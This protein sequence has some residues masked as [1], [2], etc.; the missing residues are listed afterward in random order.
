MKI[1]QL[2]SIAA[3]ALAFTACDDIK[4]GDRYEQMEVLSVARTVLLEEYT[5]QMCVNC[6]KAHE[7]IESFEKLYGQN[8]ISVSFHCGGDAFSIAENDPSWEGIT[9]GLRNDES[10]KYGEQANAY[11]LPAG[12]VDRVTSLKNYDAWAEDIRTELGKETPVNI[13][14]AATLASDGTTIDIATTIKS[15]SN[16]SG[17]LQLWVVENGITAM[18][19]L[20]NGDLDL[21]YVHNNVFRGS[22]NGMGGEAVNIQSGVHGEFQHTAAV[23]DWWKAE[24]LAIVAFVYNDGGVLQAARAKVSA[25]NAPAE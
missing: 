2:L 16:V 6:P 23:K 7:A 10:Q 12:K 8:F 1:K 18:Q 5:G 24:N 25:A 11:S 20:P 15:S 4:E 3:L 9:V 21:E 13:E 17:K 19:M 14:L 22:V